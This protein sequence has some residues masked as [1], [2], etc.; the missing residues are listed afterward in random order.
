MDE[1]KFYINVTTEWT[2]RPDKPRNARPKKFAETKTSEPIGI[3]TASRAQFIAAAL[4]A[5]NLQNAYIPGQTSGPGMRINWAGSTYVL[6][7]F[8]IFVIPR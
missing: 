7:N 2:E 6:I 1:T 4:A 3:L 8:H 5:H